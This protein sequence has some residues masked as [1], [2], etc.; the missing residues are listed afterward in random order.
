MRGDL[1]GQVA[2]YRE[3]FGKHGASPEAYAALVPYGEI[4]L[5]RQGD[6]NAALVSFERYLAGRGPL[7]VE[8]AYGRV[9]ALRALGRAADERAAI[10]AFVNAY[11]DFAATPSLRER[12]RALSAP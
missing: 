8:A 12:A 2:A 5:A 6:A 7:A 11:P 1:E 4:Q 9:R 10:E 3:L